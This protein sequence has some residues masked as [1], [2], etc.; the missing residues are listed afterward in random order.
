MYFLFTIYFYF[1]I[2]PFLL[3][4]VNIYENVLEFNKNT[5]KSAYKSKTSKNASQK[6]VVENLSFCLFEFV[7][8]FTI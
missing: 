8:V 3:Q 2:Q 4:L 5:K 7:D 1:Y 6:V